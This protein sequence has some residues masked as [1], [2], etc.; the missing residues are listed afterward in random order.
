[1]RRR[2]LLACSGTALAGLAGCLSGS[3]GEPTTDADENRTT[4]ATTETTN[5][6]ARTTSETTDE[7]TATASVSVAL[8]ALQPALV[9]MNSPDSI[10]AHPTD[11]QYLFLDATTEDG[12]PPAREEFSFR[13]AGSEYAPVSMDWPLRAWRVRSGQTEAYDA[14]SGRGLLL[15]ELPASA[16]AADGTTGT[17]ATDTANGTDATASTDAADAALTWPGGE[18]RPDSRVRRRLAAP[19]PSFSVSVEIP[20]KVS[21]SDSPTIRATA[22]NE[23]DVPGRFVAA[24]NRAGPAVAHTPVQRIS[25]LVPAGESREWEFTDASIMAD[26]ADEYAGDDGPDMTYYFSWAD[27]SASRDVRYV[28]DARTTDTA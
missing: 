22:E 20:E 28:Q 4:D 27:G 8:D 16:G 6:T 14:A 15:F 23:S 2:A 11:G 7:T 13:F 10:A 18:W 3:S 1:M 19:D 24:L 12:A 26:E 21:V 25:I 9:T 17:G 5:G